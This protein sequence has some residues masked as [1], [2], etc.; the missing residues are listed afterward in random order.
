MNSNPVSTRIDPLSLLIIRF[1]SCKFED[2]R[3]HLRSDS[4]IFFEQNFTF[5]HSLDPKIDLEDEEARDSRI[6]MSKQLNYSKNRRM[7]FPLKNMCI[8]R[9]MWA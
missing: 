2:N 4:S 9:P 6:E 7:Y 3:Q 5:K 1:L 8:N